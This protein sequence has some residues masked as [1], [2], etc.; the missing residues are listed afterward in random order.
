MLSTNTHFYFLFSVLVLS[1]KGCSKGS[2]ISLEFLFSLDIL[3]IVLKFLD[4]IIEFVSITIKQFDLLGI[5]KSRSN[6]VYSH[7]EAIDRLQSLDIQ[8][9]LFYAFL[10]DHV[11]LLKPIVNI[12][13][14]FLLLKLLLFQK[15]F[16]FT[17][18]ISQCQSIL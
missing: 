5:C 15:D 11:L 7:Q 16:L 12:L 9:I 10:V 14:F 13:A 3:S 18:N 6:Q 4:N 8:D 17:G 1:R 2:I